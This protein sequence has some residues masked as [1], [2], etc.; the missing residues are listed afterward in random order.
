MAP[1]LTPLQAK[2]K[3]ASVKP[4]PMD[5]SGLTLA[6]YAGLLPTVDHGRAESVAGH[7]RLLVRDSRRLLACCPGHGGRSGGAGYR[8]LPAAGLDLHAINIGFGAA[9]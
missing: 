3:L 5:R 2:R 8:S 7:A 6:I 1:S 9:P 4:P